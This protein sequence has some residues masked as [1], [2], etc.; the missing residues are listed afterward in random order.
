M[1]N[2]SDGSV[3]ITFLCRFSQQAH[4]G[5]LWPTVAHCGL[6]WLTALGPTVAHC[7]PLGP[8]GAHWG[9]LRCTTR[10]FYKVALQDPTIPG[11]IAKHAESF[12][13]TWQSCCDSPLDNTAGLYSCKTLKFSILFG[14]VTH[15]K[16]K[17]YRAM[18]S[19]QLIS[20]NG[21][22]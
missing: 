8:T 1:H 4:C 11:F 21:V 16:S 15:C 19:A 2:I 12:S 18:Q 22:Q 5:P 9:P 20:V 3:Q 6:M 13:N 7:G 10:H 14:S 17:H